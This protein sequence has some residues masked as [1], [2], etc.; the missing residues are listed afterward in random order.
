MVQVYRDKETEHNWEA[1][2]R[3]VTRLR[4]ILRGNA[5]DNYHDVL[6][7]GIKQMVDGILKAVESLRTTL[8]LNALALIADIGTYVGK[9]LDAYMFDH[10]LNCLIKCASTTKKIIATTSQTATITFIAHT[11][12]YHKIMNYLWLTMN[13]KNNQARLFTVIYTKA[14]L[15]THAHRDHVRALMD[16]TNSTD[17]LEQIL[18]K[19]LTDATPAAR[20]AC[21]EA[22][23]IFSEHW[24]DRGEASLPAANRKHLEKVR[25]PTPKHKHDRHMHSPTNSSSS[26]RTSSSLGSHRNISDIHEV[27]SP[28]T[29]SASNGSTGSA[30]HHGSPHDVSRT[31]TRSVSP[32]AGSPSR[33]S[34]SPHLLRSYGSPSPI[35]SHLQTSHLPPS[36]P[37][38]TGQRKTR[39][40]GLA[41]KK[42]TVALNAKRKPNLLSMLKADDLS[43]RWDGIRALARKLALVPYSPHMNVSEIQIDAG[44]GTIDGETLAVLVWGMFQEDNVRLY[45]AFSTWEGSVGI[46]LKLVSFEEYLPR[47]MLDASVEEVYLKT[48]DDIAKCQHANQALKRIK[49]FLNRS[50]PDL[51]DR[52]LLNLFAVGGFGDVPAKKPS[53]ANNKKD[54]MKLPANRRKLTKHFLEWMDELVLPLIGLSDTTDEEEV[55]EVDWLEISKENVASSWFEAD[56]H[57]KQTLVQLLP[58]V[59]KSTEGSM[60][61][62]PLVSL[63]GHLRLVNQ[64]LFE[65]MLTT[66]DEKTVNKTCRVLKIHIRP[67]TDYVCQAE[68]SIMQNDDILDVA[69]LNEEQAPEEAED[70]LQAIVYQESEEDSIAFDKTLSEDEI[71]PY[72]EVVNQASTEEQNLLDDEVH[73]YMVA[74]K[75]STT[76]DQNLLE[77][78]EY[79]QHIEEE[80]TTISQ[81][82]EEVDQQAS[83]NHIPKEQLPEPDA[84][85]DDYSSNDV[86]SDSGV[87]VEQLQKTDNQLELASKEDDNELIQKNAKETYQPEVPV[88]ILDNPIKNFDNQSELRNRTASVG[89]SYEQNE[90]PPNQQ[91]VLLECEKM[92]GDV[93]DDE[94]SDMV[95]ENNV[96][97]LSNASDNITDDLPSLRADLPTIT[98]VPYFAPKEIANGGLPVFKQNKRSAPNTAARSGAKDRTTA[99]YGLVDKMNAMAADNNTFRKMIRLCKE[100][101][102]L[103]RWDQG[104]SEDPGSELWAG[105]NSDGGN[106]VEVVQSTLL[107]LSPSGNAHTAAALELVQQLSNTQAGL[108]RFYERK[109]DERSMSLE[110]LLTER[111]LEMRSNDDPTICTAAEDALD[112]VLGA[113]DSQT[114]FEILLSY[115][116]YRLILSPTHTNSSDAW[117]G[118][119]YHPIGSAFTYLGKW[120]KEVNDTNFI[121]DWLSNGGADAFRKGMN[122]TVINIRKSC[123]D[124]IVSFQEVLGDDMYRFLSDL[125]VDQ[126][127]LVRHYAAKSLKKKASLRNLSASGQLR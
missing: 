97:R 52:L 77:T 80:K 46:L 4:G 26:L 8:A 108:F 30:D 9:S 75:Q 47:V 48:D 55:D 66:F 11:P 50:D 72:T 44:N 124:A 36:P 114:V 64:K 28:S 110:A 2:E 14:L 76:Q 40:S 70:Q 86:V 27:V 83:A 12:F 96:R 13:E 45:D 39:V 118:A 122:D 74:F 121:N 100:A 62:G 87:K 3:Y 34:T 67:V 5:P 6:M 127:N 7:A 95:I 57:V 16:R 56:S 53:L 106:F 24:R 73:P 111:L 49:L 35:P 126:I 10:F 112:A 33:R 20:E 32:R 93:L 107:Y 88:L 125:R 61:H 65:T 115:L 101:P 89:N 116:I 1:R 94:M 23:W 84:G 54:P 19:G 38:P 43:T 15:Q 17:T 103:K 63:V 58:L 81:P 90:E 31:M 51:P 92:L 42:S 68:P 123:V 37:T 99:L 102:V 120:V 71:H 21:R 29:S 117:S 82:I 22:Y 60:W 98:N 119:R 85:K 109:V 18:N 113:L 91:Q 59:S 25:N 105:G 41:R 79:E 104:G 78:D 69:D